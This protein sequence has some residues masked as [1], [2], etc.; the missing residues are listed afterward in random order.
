MATESLS[1]GTHAGPR[2]ETHVTDATVC[3]VRE[4]F[5]FSV[6]AHARPLE[7]THSGDGSLPSSGS[8]VGV[9][10]RTIPPSPLASTA[11]TSRQLGALLP[12]IG[13]GLAQ[14]SPSHLAHTRAT[15]TAYARGAGKFL[16]SEVTPWRVLNR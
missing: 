12:S 5:V 3:I 11:L 4:C 6:N 10:S 14:F 2:A 7:W 13:T 9:R 16:W 8:A 1:R 15:R